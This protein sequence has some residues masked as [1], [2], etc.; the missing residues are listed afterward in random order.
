MKILSFKRLLK[1]SI[2]QDKVYYRGVIEN[3]PLTGK[4]MVISTDIAHAVQ[5]SDQKTIQVYRLNCPETSIFS[6]NDDAH[7]RILASNKV[8]MGMIDIIKSNRPNEIDWSSIHYLADDT[9]SGEEMLFMFG[10]RGAK[11][12]VHNDFESILMFDE[13]FITLVDTL[14]ISTPEARAK[15][16]KSRLFSTVQNSFHHK[17]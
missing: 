3:R 8:S 2:Y 6:I 5:H 17:I 12:N 4:E 13:R 10:F 7:L 16:G 1:E 14:D 15:I 11:I 9:H